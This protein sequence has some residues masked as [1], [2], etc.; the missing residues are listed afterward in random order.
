MRIERFDAVDA[1]R[2]MRE[3][4]TRY[5]DDVLIIASL[6]VAGKIQFV[7]AIDTEQRPPRL[8][9][10]ELLV[11]DFGGATAAPAAAT[12]AGEDETVADAKPSPALAA[13]ISAGFNDLKA[14][15]DELKQQQSRPPRHVSGHR[16][17][18]GELPL[19]RLVR[20]MSGC[21]VPIDL[22]Q[23]LSGVISGCTQDI[24][25][26][27][28]IRSWLQ[29]KLR[30]APALEKLPNVHFLVGAHGV[31][32]SVLGMRLAATLSGS[33]MLGKAVF[34]SYKPGHDGAQSVAG[35]IVQDLEVN[36]LHAS[37]FSA[38]VSLINEHIS[39]GSLIVELPANL[40]TSELLRL[41]QRLPSALFHLVIATDSHV[42]ALQY[43]TRDQALKFTS[44]LI[45]RIDHQGVSWPTIHTL[46]ENDVPLM[47]G[48][49]GG[50]AAQ[51]LVPLDK[52]SIID[53]VVRVMSDS[54]DGNGGVES[55]RF[56][57]L[58]AL[59]KNQSNAELM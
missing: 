25:C 26:I 30:D 18:A 23:T 40:H 32:K 54:I 24:D 44:A 2:G 1:S 39:S 15:L 51:S 57:P 20:L 31:G 55:V 46:I 43:V 47:W 42:N 52:T 33:G 7:I 3:I 16:A 27:A 13:L 22:L 8:F 5:G 56:R 19:Q 50:S 36:T 11:K 35:A 41:Q 38:L 48:S 59:S 14:Q 29:A 9:T 37:D 53:E 6:R 34:V 17:G 49:H 12:P 21:T 4:N 45:T 58:V 28:A 10:P